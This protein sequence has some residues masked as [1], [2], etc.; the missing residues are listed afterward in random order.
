MHSP[1]IKEKKEVVRVRT[2]ITVVVFVATLATSVVVAPPVRADGDTLKAVVG[3]LAL[4][5]LASRGDHHDADRT[6][7]VVISVSRRPLGE[8]LIREVNGSAEAAFIVAEVLDRAGWRV[9]LDEDR[10][11]AEEESQRYGAGPVRPEGVKYFATV[12]ADFADGREYGRSSWGRSS[13]SAGESQE[14]VCRLRL[15]ISDMRG[16]S[17]TVSGIG[18]SWSRCSRFSWQGCNWGSESRNFAPSSDDAAMLVAMVAASN[19]FLY[20]LSGAVAQPQARP[21]PAPRK[22]AA[23]KSPPAP[24]VADEPSTASCPQCGQELTGKERFCPDCGRK[25][26]P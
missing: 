7:E 24:P 20:R 2:L 19:E 21:K 4:L 3:G 22:S 10:R 15:R 11:A 16:R 5:Y 8:I 17:V 26:L 1:N 18:S 9:V 25:L 23:P 6:P 14:R 12:N 13:A